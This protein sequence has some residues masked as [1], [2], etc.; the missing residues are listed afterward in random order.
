MP[1][2]L[3]V[4]SLVAAGLAL[5]GCGGGGGAD[6]RADRADAAVQALKDRIAE[7]EGEIGAASDAADAMG[8]LHAQ[9]NHHS[10]EASRLSMEIGDPADA[11]DAMGSLNAQLNY[12]AMVAGDASDAPDAMGSLHAQINYHSGEASRLSMEAGESTDAPDAM[13]SLHAQINYHMGEA[14][15]LS[16]EAGESTDSPDAMG[17]LHAQI[18][19]HMW[20]GVEA[21]DMKPV[22]RRMLRMPWEACM[23]RS[24]TTR[25]KAGESTDPADE[26][27]SLYAQIAY[28][29]GEAMR[30]DG[31][32]GDPTDAADSSPTASLHAQLNAAKGMIGSSTDTTDAEPDEDGNFPEGTSLYAQLNYW[33]KAHADAEAERVETV[34]QANIDMRIARRLLRSR[35]QS[36]PKSRSQIP[37]IR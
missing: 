25:W 6:D 27:G 32:L 35:P 26:M 21:L 37:V 31:Q 28:H 12:R 2:H 15:R 24:T 5:A 30:L 17:S 34:R 33:K 4:A 9:I 20:R 23:R 11:A 8:S 3:A 16:M 22:I 7:L 18:N 19:Y 14:S 29:R 1:R 36:W 13:G 10:G